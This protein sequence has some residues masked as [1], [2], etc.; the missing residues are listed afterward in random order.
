[1]S[2]HAVVSAALEYY[3]HAIASERAVSKYEYLDG[4]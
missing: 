3:K 1:M 4:S 2:P